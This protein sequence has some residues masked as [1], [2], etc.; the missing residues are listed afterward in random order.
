MRA[1]PQPPASLSS[2]LKATMKPATIFLGPYTVVPFGIPEAKHYQ[3]R[4]KGPDGGEL[5]TFPHG[6]RRSAESAA[7]DWL[8]AKGLDRRPVPAPQALAPLP[9][10]AAL[11]PLVITA[12]EVAAAAVPVPPELPAWAVI[13][14]DALPGMCRIV[15]HDHPARWRGLCAQAYK[16][17]HIRGRLADGRSLLDVLA[18][19]ARSR[20]E[21][22]RSGAATRIAKR[23]APVTA[24]RDA[25]TDEPLAWAV[26]DPDAP[27]G[28]CRIRDCARRGKIRGL[29]GPHYDKAR[30]AKILERVAIDPLTWAERGARSLDG[31]I[32]GRESAV[33]TAA[34]A[35][36][37]R[38]KAAIQA[39]HG[40]L[41]TAGIRPDETLDAVDGLNPRLE[42]M[43]DLF[44][45]L[46]RDAQKA[47]VLV[48]P[49]SVEMT[50]NEKRTLA[51]RLIAEAEREENLTAIE[52][53]AAELE[54]LEAQTLADLEAARV[55][56]L[57]KISA[58]RDR[59]AQRR[60]ALAAA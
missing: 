42:A 28:R 57:A 53:A 48:A 19:P 43:I 21:A 36:V 11:P 24:P 12:P 33:L 56:V 26:I 45:A 1:A 60:A 46:Q 25:P 15:G 51:A 35:D 14:P 37:E 41:Q 40:Q 20:S 49:A 17:A 38:A 34:T 55:A 31:M 27:F 44:R 7:S 47:P 10:L 23:D 16:A 52:A 6:S 39:A 3:W 8:D 50:P 18:L 13:N 9:P 4:L 29:C 2:H 5:R 22:A 59:L 58:E 54:Q 30:R 32:A